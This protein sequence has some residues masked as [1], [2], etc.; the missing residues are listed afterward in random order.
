MGVMKR[1]KGG[2]GMKVGVQ[3]GR[4]EA[5]GAIWELGGK[6]TK[7]EGTKCGNQKGEAKSGACASEGRR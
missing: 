1:E 3:R 2:A 7:I 5:G 6:R 4:W